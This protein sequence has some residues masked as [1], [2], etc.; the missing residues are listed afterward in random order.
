V[1]LD[2]R[3]EHESAAEELRIR[4]AAEFQRAQRAHTADNASSIA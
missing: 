2:D 1:L 3:P 4:I